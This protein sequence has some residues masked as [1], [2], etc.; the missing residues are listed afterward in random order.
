MINVVSSIIVYFAE[1]GELKN[2][3]REWKNIKRHARIRT[4][5]SP[6][7]AITRTCPHGAKIGEAGDLNGGSRVGLCWPSANRDETVFEKADEVVLDR[8]P[9]PHIGFGLGSTTALVNAGPSDYPKFIEISFRTSENNQVDFGSTED[10]E[11]IL[12]PTGRV[13]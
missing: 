8:T 12:L 4:Y 3:R 9:N 2:F 5:V 13:R 11:R 10:G 1:N 7:T 6:L